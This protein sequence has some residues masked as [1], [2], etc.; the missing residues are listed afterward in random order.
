MFSYLSFSY[1]LTFIYIYTYFFFIFIGV[2][3]IKDL[4]EDHFHCLDDFCRQMNS[5]DTT[6]SKIS[7]SYK[8]YAD[9][10]NIN[11]MKLCKQR[12]QIKLI[13]YSDQ[14]AKGPMHSRFIQS[15]LIEDVSFFS[16][17]LPSLI[18]LSSFSLP[19]LFF[20]SFSFIY[21]RKNF[22]YK[23]MHIQHF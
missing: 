21:Y 8:K 9:Q 15:Q 2:V 11:G 10:Y 17:S 23:L 16:F 13:E 12:E 5:I 18:I 20:H 6:S 22:V 3:Q 1:L 4:S 7:S 14:D 19:Q